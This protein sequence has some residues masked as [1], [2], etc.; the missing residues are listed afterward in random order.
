MTATG[1]VATPVQ[2]FTSIPLPPVEA[3]NHIP[4]KFL[5]GLDP[6]WIELWNAHGSKVVPASEVSIEDFRKCPQKYSFTY[7]TSR[8]K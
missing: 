2:P 1:T 5:P 8:G 3:P 7:P 6:E 4:E